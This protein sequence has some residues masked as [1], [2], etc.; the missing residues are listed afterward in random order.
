[1]YVMFGEVSVYGGEYAE[2]TF[3]LH[4]MF[5]RADVLDGHFDVSVEIVSDED[6]AI[7]FKFQPLLVGAALAVV[8]PCPEA[9]NED[10]N[11]FDG[12]IDDVQRDGQIG[13][14]WVVDHHL[15][16]AQWVRSTR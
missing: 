3:A 10:R 4:L 12:L 11:K 8:P 15:V 13:M 9:T 2:S 14:R 16:C 1:M 5:G 6:T 7:D